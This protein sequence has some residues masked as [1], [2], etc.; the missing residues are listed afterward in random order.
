[1]IGW[2]IKKSQHSEKNHFTAIQ[3]KTLIGYSKK[4]EFFIQHSD[5]VEF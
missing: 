5:H 4:A 2:W 1:M 3:T